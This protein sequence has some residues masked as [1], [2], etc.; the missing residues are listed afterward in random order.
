MTSEA[1]SV[2]DLVLAPI[3]DGV[4][5]VSDNAPT[6]ELA[7]LASEGLDQ[8]PAEVYL[9]AR[10]KSRDSR[11]TMRSTLNALAALLGVRAVYDKGHDVR[12]RYVPWGS[13]RYQHTQ[14]LM[15]A[16]NEPIIPL[17]P[18]GQKPRL[19][20][21]MAP[22]TAN[23]YRAAL[24]GVLKECRR[25]RLMTADEYMAAS[26]LPRFKGKRIKKGRQIQMGE[27]MAL[28]Q[29]CASD[30]G[31]LGRRDQAMIAVL[32]CT[33]VRRSE[34]SAF[35]VEDYDPETHTLHVRAG[36]GNQDR[37][38]YVVGGAITALEVWIAVRNSALAAEERDDEEHPLFV[39]FRKG[40]KLTTNRL[41]AESVA[42]ALIARV[43][44]AATNPLAPHDFRRTFIS[45]LL[46]AG[47]DIAV[48]SQLAGH[49]STDITAGYDRRGEKAKQKAMSK[50]HVPT[51][52]PRGGAQP[53]RAARRRASSRAAHPADEHAEESV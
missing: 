22:T 28:L 20:Y 46:E 43:E 33:G 5:I 21:R 30:P 35:D 42:D 53:A 17:T 8:N 37:I 51:I 26:D 47:E 44:Q 48:V 15:A 31:P 36:K 14:A 13:L 2:T 49:S 1:E 6:T 3:V 40:G 10:L 34:L 12:Y 38:V 18:P 16:L 50:V 19:P 52:A 4:E 39:S 41:P 27:L 11:R 25:L 7:Q 23:K 45:D 29:A 9:S 32:Y 24:L